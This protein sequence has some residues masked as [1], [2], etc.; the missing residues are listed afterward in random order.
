M[1]NKVILLFLAIIVNVA[2]ATDQCNQF[3][4]VLYGRVWQVTSY[5]VQDDITVNPNKDFEMLEPDG[6]AYQL[7]YLYASGDREEWNTGSRL[8]VYSWQNNTLTYSGYKQM[9][10][11]SPD[12]WG[13]DGLTFNTSADPDSYGSGVSELV[14]IEADTPAQV[15]II[16][17]STA[18]VTSRKTLPSAEDIT[19]IAST[20][21]FASV[22]SG[23]ENSTVTIYDKTITFS[24]TNFLITNSTYGLAWVSNNFGQWF[25]REDIPS[26][27]GFVLAAA[28]DSVNK[29]VMHDLAG[30]QIGIPQELPITPKARISLGGGLTMI[31]PAFGQ[32]E[33]I[34]V[35]EQNDTI[36]IGDHGNAMIH[37]LTAVRLAGDVN[38]DGIVDFSD[39]V[40]FAANWLSLGCL[41]P[42]WCNGA[43]IDHNGN[44]DLS[45]FV[46]ISDQYG[47]GT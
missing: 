13:P 25:S 11:I 21:K 46:I 4:I 47:E 35:D 14:S 30:N 36:F 28:K 26:N 40:V 9:P 42:Q 24:E 43:D 33:A 3:E 20:G 45:D 44:V 22:A 39:L 15:G 7:G 34:A 31:E 38:N 5:F 37:V 27:E 17:I 16:N 12:W 1:K 8:A 41:D 2:S 18:D 19:Y 29:V 32:I 10:S 23:T 6:V